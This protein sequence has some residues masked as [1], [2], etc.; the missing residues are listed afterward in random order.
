MN[1]NLD[2]IELGSFLETLKV[3]EMTSGYLHNKIRLDHGSL[4]IDWIYPD[5]S[6]AGSTSFDL[7]LVSVMEKLER[8]IEYERELLRQGQPR[9]INRHAEADVEVGVELLEMAS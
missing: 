9:L 5:A 3:Y 4:W 7:P 2:P 1:K 6:W 8:E